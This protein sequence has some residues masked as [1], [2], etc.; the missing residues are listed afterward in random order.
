MEQG[1]NALLVTSFAILAGNGKVWL[2]KKKKPAVLPLRN[3]HDSLHHL[4]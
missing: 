2:E 4:T 1:G 3:V